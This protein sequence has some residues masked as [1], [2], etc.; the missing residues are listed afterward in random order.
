MSILVLQISPRPRLRASG[1]GHASPESARTTDEYAYALSPDG[2]MLEA[3]G[4]CAAS[5]L[6]KADTVGAVLSDAD[7]AWHRIALPK[8]PA[9]K[10]RAALVGL[11]EETVLEDAELTHFAVAPEASSGQP[12]WIAA[13]DRAWLRAELAALEQ[14]GVFVDRVV[15]ASWPD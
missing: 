13:I 5:L 14:S 1:P 6:P 4:Q 12:T 15:P 9:S 8:A 3:Q 11:L 2:L 7:V 10:L